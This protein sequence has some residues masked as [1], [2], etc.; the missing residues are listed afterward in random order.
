MAEYKNETIPVAQEP[1][2]TSSADEVPEGRKTSE[3]PPF[4]AVRS[5]GAAGVMVHGPR[6]AKV[7]TA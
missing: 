2:K 7:P 4:S 3:F 1:L 6:S 5:A